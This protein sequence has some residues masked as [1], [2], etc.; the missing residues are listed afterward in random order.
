MGTRPSS[1]SATRFGSWARSRTSRSMAEGSKHMARALVPES[2]SAPQDEKVP[3][4]RGRYA[5]CE[6]LR[7]ACSWAT[8][9]RTSGRPE[10]RPGVDRGSAGRPLRRRRRYLYKIRRADAEADPGHGRRGYTLGLRRDAG[11]RRDRRVTEVSRGQPGDG[12][13]RVDT[14]CARD[15]I[16]IQSKSRER[17]L[18]SSASTTA[19]PTIRPGLRDGTAVPRRAYR[20]A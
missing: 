14:R 2:R 11:S 17:G 4:T 15:H 7:A 10:G 13:A 1:R 12:E 8:H 5:M 3:V 20:P 9:R 18:D 19:I 16:R 6:R